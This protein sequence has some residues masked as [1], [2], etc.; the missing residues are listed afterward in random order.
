MIN[1]A[2]LVGRMTRNPELRR[3]SQSD[4]VTSFALAVNRSFT[5]RDGQQ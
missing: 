5:G 4:A 2:V 1:R 3:T